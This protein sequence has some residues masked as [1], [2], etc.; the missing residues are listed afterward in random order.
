[1]RKTKIKKILCF[2]PI[3]CLLLYNCSSEG[4]TQQEVGTITGKVYSTVTG[5]PV[6][7]V[8]V[9]CGN[10]SAKTDANGAY[11]LKNVPVGR[12]KV[13]A[14]KEGYELWSKPINVRKGIN[15]LNILLLRSSS[16]GN[17]IVFSP[18]RTGNTQILI[19]MGKGKP[20][21]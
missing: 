9:S 21:L 17:E 10:I 15:A 4:I 11:S 20:I 1:M 19:Q 6:S 3:F 16:N 18:K 14:T 8:S 5:L 13:T 2:L 12:R 7:N